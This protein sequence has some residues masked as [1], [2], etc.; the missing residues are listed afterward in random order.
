MRE[1]ENGATIEA[2]TILVNLLPSPIPNGDNNMKCNKKYGELG[3][4]IAWTECDG[5][6][7]I[8]R[9]HDKTGSVLYSTSICDKCS[10]E[11]TGI[12]WQR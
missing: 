9:H 12:I 5:E 11:H 8:S 2:V 1:V 6:L 3:S 10:H 7:T 4:G